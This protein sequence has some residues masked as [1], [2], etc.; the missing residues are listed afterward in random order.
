LIQCKNVEGAA[1]FNNGFNGNYSVSDGQPLFSIAHPV[2]G[3]TSANTFAQPAALQETSLEDALI[4]V[5]KFLNAAG[6]RMA[7]EVEKLSVPPELQYTAERLLGSRF[8]TNTANNDIS[9]VYNLQSVRQGFAVNQFLTTPTF[10]NLIT[11]EPNGNKYFERDP[12]RI[13]M[14]TDPSTFILNVAAMERYSFGNSNWRADFGS[15][16]V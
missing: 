5:Q 9:A 4:G 14:F 8:R 15:Q 1:L 11:S 2:T 6:L 12:L 16:G 10:W 7:L 13:R 3:N